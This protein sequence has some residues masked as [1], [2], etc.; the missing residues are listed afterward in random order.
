MFGFIHLNKHQCDQF[1]VKH[2]LDKGWL[3]C[4]CVFKVKGSVRTH[5]VRYR[6]GNTNCGYRRNS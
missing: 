3:I 2:I 5:G 4:T 6:V 1:A